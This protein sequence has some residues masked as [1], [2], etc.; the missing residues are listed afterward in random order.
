VILPFAYDVI[1][2]LHVL[3][4]FNNKKKIKKNVGEESLRSRVKS[5]TRYVSYFM[6]SLWFTSLFRIDILCLHV[7]ENISLT[8]TKVFPCSLFYLIVACLM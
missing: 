1:S 2:I 6:Y 3:F 5:F 7:G 4:V 8:C